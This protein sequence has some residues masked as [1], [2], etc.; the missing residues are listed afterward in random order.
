MLLQSHQNLNGFLCAY[1]DHSLAS[2][3]YSI[4]N[5]YFLER[6]FNYEFQSRGQFSSDGTT[7]SFFYIGKRIEV[8]QPK[9]DLVFCVDN[10][11]TFTQILFYGVERSLLIW[12][13]LT[14]LFVDILASNFVL[15]ALITYILN[16]VSATRIRDRPLIPVY[17]A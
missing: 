2:H 6:I 1:I 11:K 15:A 5:R 3:K 17:S 12:N 14:F 9:V 10:E 4:R 7:D 16:G 13:T 8:F